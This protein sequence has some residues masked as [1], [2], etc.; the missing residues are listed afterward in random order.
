MGYGR[1][2]RRNRTL[3]DGFNYKRPG[4]IEDFLDE[5]NKVLPR[6]RTKLKAREQRRLTQAVKRARYLGLIPYTED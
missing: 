3:P 6:R 5:E 1:G 4:M 2:P